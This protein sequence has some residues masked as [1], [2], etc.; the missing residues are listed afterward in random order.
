MVV[1]AELPEP[2]RPPVAP[3]ASMMERALLL[4]VQMRFAPEL[5]TDGTAKHCCDLEQLPEEVSH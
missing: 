3:L 4:L 1:D 2:V 5:V